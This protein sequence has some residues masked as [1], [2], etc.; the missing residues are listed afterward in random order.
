MR[1][2]L[3]VAASKLE[4]VTS[5]SIATGTPFKNF[6]EYS[7]ISPASAA[8]TVPEER[9]ITGEPE[10]AA[11]SAVLITTLEESDIPVRVIEPVESL[12]LPNVI[13]VSP[14]ISE[15]TSTFED[16][17]EVNDDGAPVPLKVI[18]SLAASKPEMITLP[19]A[20]EE[21]D[22]LEL[23]VTSYK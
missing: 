8:L 6:T 5:P 21:T 14:L 2:I 19:S 15:A 12:S 20:D 3:S 4:I 16:P 13:T 10:S 9:S 22:P 1:T 17:P 11:S 7:K 18:T 23:N